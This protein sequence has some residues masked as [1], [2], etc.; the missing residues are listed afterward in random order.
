MSTVETNT[1]FPPA[2]T[3]ERLDQWR[4][5]AAAVESALSMGGEPG[6]DLLVSRA[7]E[8]NEAVNEWT[9]GL[10]TCLELGARGLRDEALQWHAEGFLE[11]GDLLCTD[12]AGRLG[13]VAGDAGATTGPTTSL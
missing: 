4:D 1:G 13:G 7:A 2:V 3:F 10:Q 12:S 9:A 8:W 11:A 5:I 6:M